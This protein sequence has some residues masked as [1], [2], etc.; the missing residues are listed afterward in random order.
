MTIIAETFIGQRIILDGSRRYDECRFI[1]CELVIRPNE[2][3]ESPMVP[4]SGGKVERCV[5]RLD[6]AVDRWSRWRELRDLLPA[7]FTGVKDQNEAYRE[8]KEELSARS[9]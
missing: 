3:S 8:V 1:E 6:F 4:I 5:W 7:L 9:L 2:L